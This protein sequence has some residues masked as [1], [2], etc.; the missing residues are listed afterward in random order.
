MNMRLE[1]SRMIPTL[2]ANTDPITRITHFMN[3]DDMDFDSILFLLSIFEKAIMLHPRISVVTVVD[4]TL[5]KMD[6]P[7]IRENMTAPALPSR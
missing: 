5:V 6:D 2:S 4:R 1:I 7:R 3:R